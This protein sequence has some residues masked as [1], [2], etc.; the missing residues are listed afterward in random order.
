M[1]CWWEVPPSRIRPSSNPPR[2][3]W[4]CLQPWLWTTV[5]QR[6]AYE[7]TSSRASTSP[8][9]TT[10]TNPSFQ[11]HEN[12]RRIKHLCQGPGGTTWGG[13]GQS[14][15][16]LRSWSNQCKALGGPQ[17]VG[18]FKRL[19][20]FRSWYFN[21]KLSTLSWDQLFNTKFYPH[22]DSQRGAFLSRGV[23]RPAGKVDQAWQQDLDKWASTYSYFYWTFW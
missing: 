7:T 21:I 14:C 1:T 23:L 3:S 15:V 16:L 10:S 6:H 19:Q 18:F 12:L 17:K 9:L 8:A 5:A 4:A 2:S 13:V 22:R 20:Q 11:Q